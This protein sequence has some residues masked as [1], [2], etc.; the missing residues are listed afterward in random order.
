MS[1]HCGLLMKMLCGQVL[2]CKSL[3]L[4]KQGGEIFFEGLTKV[5]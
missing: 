5:S 3:S 2:N 1:A 4:E